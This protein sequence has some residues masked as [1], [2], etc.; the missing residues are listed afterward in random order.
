MASCPTKPYVIVGANSHNITFFDLSQSEPASDA[1]QLT[2]HTH[3]IP[4]VDISPCGKFIVSV[5][6]DFTI[7][8]WDQKTGHVL[9][10]NKLPQWGWG[11]K[12]I[13]KDSIVDAYI[14]NSVDCAIMKISGIEYDEPYEDIYNMDMP[15]IER[16]LSDSSEPMSELIGGS[17]TEEDDFDWVDEEE[18][19]E[20]AH[21]IEDIQTMKMP[22]KPIMNNS[23][24][25]IL[26][27]LELSTLTH[28]NGPFMTSPSLL[29]Q[30]NDA[31]LS[32]YLV[33]ASTQ[34][35][36]ILFDSNLEVLASVAKVL[37]RPYDSPFGLFPMIRLSI[38]QYIPELS[39]LLVANQGAFSLLVFT[40]RFNLNTNEYEYIPELKLPQQKVESTVIGLCYHQVE[41]AKSYNVYLMFQTGV[42]M[43]Y[44][45]QLN[46][47]D[48]RYNIE[49]IEV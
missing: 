29:N 9:V 36:L 30:E 38:V 13:R 5:S 1:P 31:S 6:V 28:P 4:S 33:I 41:K 19:E 16:P 14:P 10:E 20:E 35:S 27:R 2:G 7:K 34:D 44:Q 22:Q 37:D 48:Q 25:E 15:T 45:I 18:E 3:N 49:T 43:A 42:F 40:I 17:D 24:Q 26:K 12:F 47:E 46:E 11:V 39:L 23:N 21:A 8:I 32:D